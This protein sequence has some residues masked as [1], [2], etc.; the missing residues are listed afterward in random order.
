MY[1]I[2]IYIFVG[3]F[4][5]FRTF[6]QKVLWISMHQL[7]P[8]MYLYNLLCP[9]LVIIF[10][11]QRIRGMR[12]MRKA[13]K[14]ARGIIRVRLIRRTR[15]IRKC[16]QVWKENART[17]KRE[18]QSRRTKNQKKLRIIA[19]CIRYGSGKRWQNHARLLSQTFLFQDILPIMT[20]LQRCFCCLE[21]LW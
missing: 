10:K 1:Y 5:Q 9:L 18:I 20:T 4:N 3:K 7:Q 14:R 12:K 19:C 11:V 13:T 17:G 6:S 8:C 16:N 2:L 15:R 21:S